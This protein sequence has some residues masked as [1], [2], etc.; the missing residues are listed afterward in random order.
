MISST[1]YNKIFGSNWFFLNFCV[2]LIWSFVVIFVLIRW[3]FR[4]CLI[5]DY[6]L[7]CVFFFFFWLHFLFCVWYDIFML[8]LCISNCLPNLTVIVLHMKCLIIWLNK[9]WLSNREYL[10]RNPMQF[11][12]SDLNILWQW[13]YREIRIELYWFSFFFKK[14]ILIFCYWI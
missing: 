8:I 11:V 13:Y 10:L 1:L 3:Y 6:F 2:N 12:F 4:V 9:I 14:T 5:T 7:F